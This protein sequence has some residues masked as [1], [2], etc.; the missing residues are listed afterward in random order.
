[1]LIWCIVH[2]LHVGFVVFKG[3][4]IGTA[5]NTVSL[6]LSGF[7]LQG[8]DNRG[9]ARN[10]IALFLPRTT[11]GI[12]RLFTF[13]PLSPEQKT[14]ASGERSGRGG[15]VYLFFLRWQEGR[16]EVPGAGLP[17]TFLYGVLHFGNGHGP[18]CSCGGFGRV[19]INGKVNEHG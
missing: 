5:G 17:F 14:P 6:G 7:T 10:E 18:E 15:K 2:V 12:S 4:R 8:Y 9:S 16:I 3:G 13:Q 19:Q 1:M 11:P